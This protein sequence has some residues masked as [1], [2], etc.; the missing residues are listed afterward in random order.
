MSGA[1]RQTAR[2]VHGAASTLVH[3]RQSLKSYE[4]LDTLD[5]NHD[6]AALNFFTML[7]DKTAVMIMSMQ[8]DCERS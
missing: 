3:A 2:L 8:A 5:T 1:G 6:S 4:T 7:E